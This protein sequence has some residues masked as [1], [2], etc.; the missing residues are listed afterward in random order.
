MQEC[1]VVVQWARGVC[2]LQ[3]TAHGG[4]SRAHGGACVSGSGS[5]VV[6]GISEAP[7]LLFER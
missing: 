7:A 3:H 5:A 1:S 6:G 4:D 2:G